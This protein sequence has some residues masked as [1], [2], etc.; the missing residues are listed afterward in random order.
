MGAGC[1]AQLVCTACAKLMS[2]NAISG[3]VVA[4]DH[5]TEKRITT[6][7]LNLVVSIPTP[8]QHLST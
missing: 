2:V 1:N 7:R 6:K 3:E 8:V 4:C 5:K